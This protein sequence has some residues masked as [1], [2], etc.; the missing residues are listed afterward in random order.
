MDIKD[1]LGYDINQVH[2]NLD[3]MPR[4]DTEKFFKN[5]GISQNRILINYIDYHVDLLR[6]QGSLLKSTLNSA[7]IKTKGFQSCTPSRQGEILDAAFRGQILAFN[8]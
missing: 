3:N 2:Y 4:G 8:S 1:M 7:K 6:S 5:M